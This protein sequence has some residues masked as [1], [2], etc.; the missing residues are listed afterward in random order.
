MQGRLRQRAYE[1]EGSFLESADRLKDFFC[2]RSAPKIC[3]DHAAHFFEVKV[4][5]KRR[6]GGHG[7]K[8]KEAIQII[9]SAVDQLAV[10]LHHI[11]C[12]T[13]LVQR[14]T[15]INRI[16]RVQSECKRSYHAKVSAAAANSPEQI[17]VFIGIR[18]HKVP[19]RQ[20]DIGR[21]EIVDG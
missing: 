3:P 2:L 16:N 8:S 19:I 7:H 4:L 18:F 12:F 6:G 21:D 9:G 1:V 5:W 20:H 15:A 17:R 11:F 13:Q 10:P 14:W